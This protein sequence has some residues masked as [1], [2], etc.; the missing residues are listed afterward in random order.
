MLRIP[1]CCT[2]L[3]EKWKIYDKESL[4]KSLFQQIEQFYWFG[5]LNRLGKYNYSVHSIAFHTH[6]KE[7]SLSS[8]PPLWKFAYVRHPYPSEFP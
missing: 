1:V 4:K 2:M 5:Y 7:N 6:W 8:P 3:E